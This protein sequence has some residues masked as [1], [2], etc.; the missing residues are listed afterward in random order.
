METPKQIR[1]SVRT[2]R[3]TLLPEQ[4]QQAAEQLSIRVAALKVFKEAQHI[5]GY[6]AFDGEMDPENLLQQALTAG[7]TIYLPILMGEN[8][9]LFAPYRPGDPLVPNYFDIPEPQVPKEQLV[10]PQELDLVLTPLVAFDETG[11]RMGM[12]GG[13]Y[14]RSFAF[15]SYPGHPPKPQLLGLAYE[16]QKWPVLNRQ[17][18]DI[19]LHGIATEA[20]LY[21]GA[22]G[23]YLE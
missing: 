7:K 3:N 15:L 14:D 18:W 20:T 8:P 12:G 2:L 22:D 10:S 4:R 6:L 13:F 1:R 9:M 16:L 19:P 11:T 17:P 5:A 21:P 23:Q